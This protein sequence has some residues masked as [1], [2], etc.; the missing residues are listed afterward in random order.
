VEPQTAKKVKTTYLRKKKTG[1]KYGS[2]GLCVSA[3]VGVFLTFQ[4]SILNTH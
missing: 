2:T 4:I 3:G 1:G